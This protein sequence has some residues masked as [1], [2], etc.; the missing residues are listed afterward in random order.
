MTDVK[1]KK[2][3]IRDVYD[4][5]L[6][7]YLRARRKDRCKVQLEWSYYIDMLCKDGGIT[8]KRYENAVF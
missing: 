4:N 1:I 2:M 7:A 5:N 3:F 8:Q 6:S